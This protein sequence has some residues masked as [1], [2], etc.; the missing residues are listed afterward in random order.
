MEPLISVIIPVYQVEAYVAHCIES[1]TNQTYRNLEIIIVN[2]DSTDDTVK[3]CERYAKADSRIKVVWQG[4]RGLSDA[5]NTGID[6]A[7][8]E[9]IAFV[10]GDDYVGKKYI[11][12]MYNIM[13]LS[14]SD[15]V[16]C[17]FQKVMDDHSEEE[18]RE[19]SYTV[20]SRRQFDLASY[21]ILSWKCNVVWNKLY[22]S[23]LFQGIRYPVEKNH[24]DEFTT[25][26]LVW[27]ANKI[28]VTNTRLYFYRQRSDSL[29]G[30]AYSLK[31]LDAQEAYREREDFYQEKG[32]TEVLNLVRMQHLEWLGWQ[33]VLIK[34]NNMETGN[35]ISILEREMD[36]IKEKCKG[37]QFYM[38]G[39]K[40][41]GYL[42]PFSRIPY[43]S[44]IILYGAGDLGTQYYRQIM[45]SN[46]CDVAA[47]IDS[48]AQ[49]HKE[50]GFPVKEKNE[51]CLGDINVK[52]MVIAIND[53][54]T[55][56]KIKE[57]WAEVC[58]LNKIV[59]VHEIIK[60]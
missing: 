45:E 55:V 37:D 9:Y 34:E 57:E 38:K 42:F 5:R 13:C 24:E 50:M 32:E 56:K 31:R 14:G 49:K 6:I 19:G 40:F 44:R 53:D 7:R 51:V 25:Y 46:Y 59:I 3:I 47:W 8:G 11:E 58:A 22:K 27:R 60:V 12:V 28:A 33:L 16:Q 15:I 43:G 41:H 4:K 18:Q 35:L 48:N 2:G 54:E 10:D 20:Y 21:T 39:L 17:N 23:F 1:I 36:C 26:K 29:M 30:S 52:Y